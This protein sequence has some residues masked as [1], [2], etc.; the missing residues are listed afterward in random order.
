MTQAWRMLAVTVGERDGEA[1][2]RTLRRFEAWLAAHHLPRAL[3]RADGQP[4]S[5]VVCVSVPMEESAKALAFR[6]FCA[7]LGLSGGL[8]QWRV[9]AG[10]GRAE[11]AGDFRFSSRR[12]Q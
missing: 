7:D 9:E 12:G 1:L 5:R 6:T 8:V 3:F 2:A 11:E 4:K 10:T